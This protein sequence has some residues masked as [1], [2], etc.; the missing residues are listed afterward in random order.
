VSLDDKESQLRARLRGLNRVVVAFSGGVDSALLYYV[1]HRELGVG[2]LGVIADSPSL[3]RRELSAAIALAEV[4]GASL[5]VI[6]ADEHLDPRYL[7]N[8]QQRC[9]YCRSALVTALTPIATR[10]QASIA[11]GAIADDLLDDR[12]GMRAAEQAGFVAPLLEAGFS[13]SDVRGLAQRLG[14]TVADKPASACLAS[15]VPRG[16]P[17]TLDRLLAIERGEE[18]LRSLGFRQVRVRDRNGVARVEVGVDELVRAKSTSLWNLIAHE[19]P[20]LG[21]RSV[22][23]AEEG[24]QSPLQGGALPAAQSPPGRG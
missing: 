10:H 21:F 18:L 7:V 20:A 6:P 5:Q 3:P 14:L 2:C 23:L 13:K 11:Y 15:R 16:T 9:Y 1:A 8:D 19:L 24:Y 22:E 17:I 12:P 4:W